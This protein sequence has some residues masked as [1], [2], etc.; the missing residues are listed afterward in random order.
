MENISNSSTPECHDLI[1]PITLD[2]YRDPV[3]AGDGHVYERIA[4]FQW[5]KQHGTSPLTREPL[6]VDDLCSEENIKQLCQSYR[7]NSVAYSCQSS[8]ISLPFSPMNQSN[9]CIQRRTPCKRNCNIKCTLLIIMATSFIT[10]LFIIAIF[11]VFYFHPF[12]S[13]SSSNKI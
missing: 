7:S 10:I 1:C 4:I 13:I 12:N 9:T 3:L 8:T 2:V 6:N 11:I 5:I